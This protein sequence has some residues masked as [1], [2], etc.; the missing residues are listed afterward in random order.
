L[1]IVGPRCMVSVFI[2]LV[3]AAARAAFSLQKKKKEILNFHPGEPRGC[4][5]FSRRG[6]GGGGSESVA[7]NARQP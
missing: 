7:A 3:A 2:L 1:F 4:L 6:G 5:L